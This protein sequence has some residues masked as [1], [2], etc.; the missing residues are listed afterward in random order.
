MI[1]RQMAMTDAPAPKDAFYRLL[2]SAKEGMG[3]VLFLKADAYYHGGVTAGFSE[4]R[5]EAEKEGMIE[6]DEEL[7]GSSLD[8]VSRV[9]HRIQSYAHMHLTKEKEKEILP[10]LMWSVSLDPHNLSAVLTTAFTLDKDFG[11]SDEAIKILEKGL[12]ENPESW[13]I[14]HDLGKL[15]FMRKKNYGQSERY[16]GIAVDKSAGQELPKDMLAQTLYLLAE[17]R[18]ALGKNSEALDAYQKAL[19]SFQD[20]MEIPLKDR[21][22]NKIRN[23]E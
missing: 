9:N 5:G 6:A 22:R 3:D 15:Y 1:D 16:L 8:W 20:S 12:Q 17:S 13:E 21:I 14:A 10:F 23:L 18:L 11:K 2:G 7:N 19:A 4:K